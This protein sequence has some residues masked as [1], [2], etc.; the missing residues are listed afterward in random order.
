MLMLMLRPHR[1]LADGS[2]R[3]VPIVRSRARKFGPILDERVLSVKKDMLI[4]A[5]PAGSKKSIN[6][7]PRSGTARSN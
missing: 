3:R 5:K 4:T 7:R 2:K 1:T 6:T